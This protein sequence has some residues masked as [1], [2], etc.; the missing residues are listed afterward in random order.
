MILLDVGEDFVPALPAGFDVERNQM[1]VRRF[2]IQPVA[3]DA[4]AAIAQLK[5][6]Q[7]L[8][9]IVPDLM[10]VARIDCVNGIRNHSIENTVD[11]QRRAAGA[12]LSTA[13]RQ[14][15]RTALKRGRC[16]C[17]YFG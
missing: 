2:E 10:A 4:G 9:D 16:A 5:G 17:P 14:F 6:R 1:A 3:I 8:P 11:K 13:L 15:S 7:S 12:N